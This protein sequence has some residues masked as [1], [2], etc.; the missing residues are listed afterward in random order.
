MG[1]EGGDSRLV[2]GRRGTVTGLFD[3]GYLPWSVAASFQ[4]WGFSNKMKRNLGS[5]NL[6]V[7]T[8]TPLPP[9]CSM[10]VVSSH[11]AGQPTHPITVCCAA[12]CRKIDGRQWLRNKTSFITTKI[13]RQLTK[14]RFLFSL[15]F[16]K[17]A[18]LT[19][20]MKSLIFLMQ[21]WWP[22]CVM[23]RWPGQG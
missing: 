2:W 4:A 12:S 14:F 15:F 6:V 9:Q 11:D 1:K 22:H 7:V 10:W 20:L 13:N 5:E 3:D 23:A 18:F 17:S 16:L 21:L 19:Y 8:P